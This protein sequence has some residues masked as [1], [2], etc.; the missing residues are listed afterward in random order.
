MCGKEYVKGTGGSSR[1]KFCVCGKEYCVGDRILCAPGAIVCAGENV[2]VGQK[3]LCVS[4][5]EDH[6]SVS[7][8]LLTTH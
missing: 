7:A 4:E 3:K 2:G 1:G 6:Q 8:T 5:G